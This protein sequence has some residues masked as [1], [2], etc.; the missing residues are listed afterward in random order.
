MRIFIV[1]ITTT[2]K[3]MFLETNELTVSSNLFAVGTSSSCIVDLNL[4]SI[5]EIV[6]SN[7]PLLLNHI[8]KDL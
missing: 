4:S 1:R 6:P 5:E 2:Q 3:P 7:L 8:E